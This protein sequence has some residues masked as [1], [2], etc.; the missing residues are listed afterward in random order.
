V[1][2]S[3]AAEAAA[4]AL[5][6]LVHLIGAGVLVW[7]M[8]DGGEEGHRPGWR[9]WWPRDDDGAPP[10]EPEPPRGGGDTVPVLPA[11][12]PAG[13]RLREPGRLADAKPR[14]PRRPAHV[15]GPE[16]EPAQRSS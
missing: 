1:S 7:A 11:S 8:L 12:S 10:E 9:D 13:V 5:T 14:P 6:I 16:R 4:L 3:P 2:I 15:P